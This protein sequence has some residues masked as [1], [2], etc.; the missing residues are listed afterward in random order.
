MAGTVIV[1]IYDH[2]YYS[3][4]LITAGCILV[5]KRGDMAVFSNTVVLI[6]EHSDKRGSVGIILNLPLP[7]PVSEV[8]T[9]VPAIKGVS[10]DQH[11]IRW[12]P[13][14]LHYLRACPFKFMAMPACQLVC[15]TSECLD[16][17]SVRYSKTFLR[18]PAGE[19]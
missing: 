18:R 13:P 16:R 2:A 9:G 1:F 7:M 5:A 4:L 11:I 12:Q 14:S 17:R 6:T 10:L 3:V 8:A 15:S 19:R